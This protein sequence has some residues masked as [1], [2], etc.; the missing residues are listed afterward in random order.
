M[1]RLIEHASV[2]LVM[3][4]VIIAAIIMGWT[5]TSG[6]VDEYG[7]F[8]CVAFAMILGTILPAFYIIYSTGGL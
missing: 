2:E 7:P 6:L 1:D 5:F 3:I 8:L 4:G